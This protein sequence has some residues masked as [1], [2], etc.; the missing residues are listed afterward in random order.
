MRKMLRFLILVA[1]VT[2]CAA[3]DS[4]DNKK[5][6]HPKLV[7]GELLRS[8]GEFQ[9]AI[10]YYKQYL[11]KKPRS[12]YVHLKIAIIYDE[13]LNDPISA[14][15][16]YR[17]VLNLSGSAQEKAQAKMWLELCEKRLNSPEKSAVVPVVD[18][19]KKEPRQI[20]RQPQKNEV[21]KTPDAPSGQAKAQEKVTQTSE[22]PVSPSAA[23]KQSDDLPPMSY[24]PAKDEFPKEYVIQRGDTLSGISKKFY[25]TTRH[26]KKIMKANGLANANQLKVGKKIVIPKID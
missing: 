1:V 8:K 10:K 3:C 24:E 20:V 7:K 11:E 25:G 16:H 5:M 4:N 18:L 17:E 26:Y 23:V 9:E 14:I 22:A 19:P 12:S 6:N 21:P 13:H 15:Y 2:F